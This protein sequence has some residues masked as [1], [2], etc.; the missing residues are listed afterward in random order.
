M[1]S[2][3]SVVM[4]VA[5]LV[6]AVVVTTQASAAWIIPADV[7]ASSEQQANDAAIRTIDGSGLSE[8]ST[9]GLHAAGPVT[10]WSFKQGGGVVNGDEW[11]TFDLGA[12]YDLTDL[13]IWQFTRTS[14]PTD[15]N[16]GV[17]FF[18]VLV[19]A[20]GVDFTEVL[21]NQLLAKAKNE[22]GDNLPD[23]DEPVQTFSLAVDGVRYIQLGVDSTWEG[24]GDWQGGF[25]EV[26][27][28]GEAAIPEPA[29]LA[30]IG[31]GGLMMLKR[32]R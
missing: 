30:L 16:R 3:K 5:A 7:I 18:D 32:R 8:E 20:N 9:A 19:S 25:G 31:L 2:S 10:S 1:F 28:E 15:G 14:H 13:H 29:S 17:K 26:R 6:V 21:S 27:F 4:F 22:N 23:G 24:N 11:I 12:A